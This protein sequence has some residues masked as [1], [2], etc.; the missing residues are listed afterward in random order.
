[1]NKV[2]VTGYGVVSPFGIGYEALING[3]KSKTNCF[4]EQEVTIRKNSKPVILPTG[5]VPYSSTVYDTLPTNIARLITP[6]SLFACLAYIEAKERAFLSNEDATK[7]SIY[8][9]ST[10]PY[11]NTNERQLATDIFKTF[12]NTPAFILAEY[13]G[14]T[15][16]V[17]A[18]CSACSTGL[19]AVNL[20]VEA[21]QSG[22]TDI[23]ICGATEE[24]SE[25]LAKIFVKLGIASKTGCRPFQDDRDG[26][27][28]SEGAGIIILESE[29]HA[30]NRLAEPKC[31]IKGTGHSFSSNPSVATEESILKCMLDA[32]APF[33]NAINGLGY[34][35]EL[36][37]CAHATGTVAGDA[38][39]KHAI[40]QF[41]KRTKASRQTSCHVLTLKEYLG[42]TMA[43]SGIIEL[44]ACINSPNVV[45]N[46]AFGLGGVNCS[47]LVV[48]KTYLCTIM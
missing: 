37:I 9:A 20:A 38:I 33:I 34:N 6:M 3:I 32:Y 39:E 19:Q 47:T 35:K 27:V 14:T 13:I 41:Q 28:I 43:A 26:T 31:Y 8:L 1:M 48:P 10:L 11:I 5:R 7:A 29:E 42:H 15:G 30:N 22:Q 16:K 23:A 36:T 4:I 45:L 17:V 2:V 12:T 44:I 25:D 18:P 46:N 21:I 40:E 24:W